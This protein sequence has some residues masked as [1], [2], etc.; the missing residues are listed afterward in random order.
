[1]AHYISI[2]D[3]VAAT[4]SLAGCTVT[5]LYPFGELARQRCSRDRALYKEMERR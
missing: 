3:L 1:M 5:V 2:A 4:P